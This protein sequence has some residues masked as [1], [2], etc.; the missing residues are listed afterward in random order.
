MFA[1]PVGKVHNALSLAEWHVKNILILRGRKWK[2]SAQEHERYQTIRHRARAKSIGKRSKN[3]PSNLSSCLFTGSSSG[4]PRSLPYIYIYV[5]IYILVIV[6]CDLPLYQYKPP[7]NSP[8]YDRLCTLL[9]LMLISP[10]TFRSLEITIKKPVRKI[11][12]YQWWRIIRTFSGWWLGHPSEKY[13]SSSI[14]M[15]SN[16]RYGKIKLMAAKPPTSI[17]LHRI[18]YLW[19][20]VTYFGSHVL[21]CFSTLHSALFLGRSMNCWFWRIAHWLHDDQKEPS[22]LQSLDSQCA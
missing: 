2:T 17:C 6:H 10:A 5:Y 15:I 3:T 12:I 11:M 19:T 4:N 8:V 16:P 18:V 7:L 13:M 1:V 20:R 21:T 14:G 22:W 9:F